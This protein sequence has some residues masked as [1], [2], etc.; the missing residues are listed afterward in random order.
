MCMVFSNRINMF[1]VQSFQNAEMGKE[2]AR[3][4]S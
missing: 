1:I 3:Y 2:K 4:Y